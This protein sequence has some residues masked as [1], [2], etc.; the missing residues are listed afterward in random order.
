MT[1]FLPA[2]R[3]RGITIQSAAI[4][5]HWPP[6]ADRNES[7]L[8]KGLEPR[9]P[10]TI[11]L[12]DTPGHA[13]FTFEVIR[14]L[15]ILDGA[16]TILDGVAGVE[17]QTEKVWHQASTCH[18]PRIIFV[19]KLDR[20]GAAFGNTVKEIAS[21]LHTWPIVCQIPWYKNDKL[22]GI[23]DVVEYCGFDWSNSVVD[24][25]TFEKRAVADLR[26]V[27]PELVS[28]MLKARNAL[29]EALTEHDD[30]LV[31]EFINTGESFEALPAQSIRQ[32][33]R[34]VL[35]SPQQKITPVF[36]GASFRNVGV[37]PL[38][39]AVD[40]L[41]PCPAD[42]A[43]PA[44][45][46]GED[47]TS[48]RRFIQ[49][50]ESGTSIH[51]P[52]QSKRKSAKEGVSNAAVAN[53]S[54]CA[55]AFKVVSDARL[56]TLIYVRVYSG[57]ISRNSLL[58]NTNLCVSERAI[59]LLKMYA[60]QSTETETLSVGEIGVIVGLKHVRTG[61]T[62]IS[63]VGS[64]AKNNPPAPF[65]SLQMQPIEVPPP[66]FFASVEPTSLSE[67]KNMHEG[68]GLLL[69]EDPSL[70]VQND[71][72]SGQTWLAGMGELHLEIARDRLIDH[73]KV[74]ARMGKIAISYR[75]AVS[76][77]SKPLT[78]TFDRDI[79]GKRAAASCAADVKPIADETQDSRS[80]EHTHFIQLSDCNILR[81]HHPTLSAN[82]KPTSLDV[83]GL[84]PD[85][86]MSGIVGSLTSG[87][88]GALS[89]GPS[90]GLPI[91]ST[92]VTI[93]F[94]PGL[95][96]LP[97]TTPAALISA[98]RLAITAAMRETAKEREVAL[99]EPVMLVTIAANEE[100]MGSVIHDLSSSR[101]AQVLSLDAEADQHSNESNTTFEE[102][103]AIEPLN[104]VQL[105]KV[106]TP[107]DLYAHSS[108][109][110]GITAPAT[111]HR[112]RQIRAR[113]PLREMV[114]Y[115][116]HLRSLTGG[117]GSFVMSVEGFEKVAG[118]K[119]RKILNDLRGD[120]G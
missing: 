50:G 32:A 111:Q 99:M 78:R 9:V 17:A 12:I 115:L 35:Q 56:G 95:H 80:T 29:V 18:I 114:G 87:A 59:R 72:D 92:S 94:D 15:R 1:D 47:K 8:P 77:A 36:C 98:A 102:D 24:G 40:D 79:A 120:F 70:S 54:A 68:L 65:A 113:V 88:I 96:L 108:S 119:T 30:Q 90:H 2:E 33:I 49:A 48:L 39:D 83:S 110:Q 42:T 31:N 14:S 51:R 91:H 25:S 7:S 6:K 63:Y 66:L 81:I 71:E 109:V 37:Q 105:E 23:G 41:L 85:I 57:S 103:S 74:K 45:S 97:N 75:E 13:D 16:V 5:F 43:D 93:H 64:S 107:P 34:R 28:E 53:L 26:S 55:L 46:L 84:P 22:I 112:T 11:N 67:E 3:A 61:D 19:N 4:T 89:R 104:S 69:R 106:Y 76:C 101:G 38:L 10:H 82:G 21:R 73:F 62:L 27:E 58:F 118:Q 116:K 44:I 100:S 60:S 117:R 86:S 52:G 20:D